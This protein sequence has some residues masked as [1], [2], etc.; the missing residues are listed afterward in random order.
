MEK[1][2]EPDNYRDKY[3]LENI[4][5]EKQEDFDPSIAEDNSEDDEKWLALDRP[6][7]KFPY[8]VGYKRNKIPSNNCDSTSKYRRQRINYN[9]NNI[10]EADIFHDQ[11]DIEKIKLI[12][13]M[14]VMFQT[15][16]R[17]Q[18]EHRNNFMY[19]GYTFPAKW[20]VTYYLEHEDDL[21]HSFLHQMQKEMGT[22]LFANFNLRSLHGWNKIV[23]KPYTYW[24]LEGE[25]EVPIA[26]HYF[27]KAKIRFKIWP[28]TKKQAA[29]PESIISIEE[30]AEWLVKHQDI[31]WIKVLEKTELHFNEFLR[32]RAEEEKLLKEERHLQ[33]IKRWAE[34]AEIEA[35]RKKSRQR[36]SDWMNQLDDNIARNKKIEEQ[37]RK[38]KE[39]KIRERAKKRKN[40][41]EELKDLVYMVAR[42]DTEI[43]RVDKKIKQIK[44]QIKR[45]ENERDR[46]QR[47]LDYKLK[48][49]QKAIPMPGDIRMKSL[50]FFEIPQFM[51]LI[52]FAIV[53]YGLGIAV[54]GAYRDIWNIS[55][56]AIKKI[57]EK[58]GNGLYKHALVSDNNFFDMLFDRKMYLRNLMA[59]NVTLSR[60]V[61]VIAM[62]FPNLY[63]IGLN[64]FMRLWKAAAF[65]EDIYR[66]QLL[67]ILSDLLKKKVPTGFILSDTPMRTFL[68]S[69]M[70]KV[71]LDFVVPDAEILY[72]GVKINRT[73][74]SF[75]IK[76]LG[77]YFEI[78]VEKF[79][80]VDMTVRE[81]WDTF[82]KKDK[83]LAIQNPIT[84]KDR[85]QFMVRQSLPFVSHYFKN[86]N[87]YV[88]NFPTIVRNFDYKRA[89]YL[90]AV[91]KLSSDIK[92]SNLFQN[93]SLQEYFTSEK[94]R[95]IFQLPENKEV[96][97]SIVT[98]DSLKI[99]KKFSTHSTHL[100]NRHNVEIKKVR[101]G[102]RVS[103]K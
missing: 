26:I 72:Y 43:A 75:S 50:Y 6:Q 13:D 84:D 34:I 102:K 99:V 4:I 100:K 33:E 59:G 97:V 25:N 40:A 63:P 37:R 98:K 17:L 57:W 46:Y 89:D 56:P 91:K 18:F 31:N 2:N 12:E 48:R 77:H 5:K 41:T 52:P 76:E 9:Q 80:L 68:L 61:R 32:I 36:K 7:Q 11:M 60:E 83:I 73:Q 93:K 82:A 66:P 90:R 103:L 70:V 19:D 3:V 94:F 79:D 30:W 101:N 69:P 95:N 54:K 86:H 23:L 10:D 44:V 81:A 47:K 42:A 88:T 22:S 58:F 14:A 15:E 92:N 96:T 55:D 67:T 28:T 16:E 64:R 29:E 62:D 51:E 45:I 38:E 8:A 39:R 87:L 53:A 49:L 65:N 1:D 71:A 20:V 21:S 24:Q 74:K 35:Q 27:R 85:K 78:D